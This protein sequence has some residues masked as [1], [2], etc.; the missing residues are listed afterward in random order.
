MISAA[1]AD[2]DTA[3]WIA[4]FAALIQLGT[5]IDSTRLI[6]EESESQIKIQIS[7]MMFM[8]PFRL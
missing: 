5:F 6:R 7:F 3:F 4:Y 2:D 8:F 1:A